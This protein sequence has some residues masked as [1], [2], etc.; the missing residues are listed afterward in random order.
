MKD[1]DCSGTHVLVRGSRV[2]DNLPGVQALLFPL[3]ALMVVELHLCLPF[4]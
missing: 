2:G 4:D 3:L 1:I